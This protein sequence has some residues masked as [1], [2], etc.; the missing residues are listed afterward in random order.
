MNLLTI[1]RRAANLAEH[2]AILLL[3]NAEHLIDAVASLA[4]KLALS[5]AQLLLLVTTREPLGIEGEW[6]YRVGSPDRRRAGLTDAEMPHLARGDE[7]GHRADRVLDRHRGI[8]SG[9]AID[10][11]RIDAESLRDT[12]EKAQLLD[13]VNTVE[14]TVSKIIHDA[15]RPAGSGTEAVCEAGTV[16]AERAAFWQ[17]LAEDTDRRMTIDVTARQ[18]R[19]PLTIVRDTYKEGRTAYG[20]RL[21]LVRPDQFVAWT[22]DAAPADAGAV[23]ARGVGLI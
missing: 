12:A 15:R 7:L 2:D 19:V 11:D 23:I 13:D 1:T 10:V 6:V 8:E 14:Y 5:C 21:I 17:P 4:E 22:G 3:D 16:V 9:G 20:Q 18:L